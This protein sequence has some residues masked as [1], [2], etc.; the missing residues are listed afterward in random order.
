M[1]TVLLSR[2]V[3]LG[4][5]FC[6]TTAASAAP[7]LIQAQEVV[8]RNLV[9]YVQQDAILISET[10]TQT[11][12]PAPAVRPLEAPTPTPVP[13]DLSQ[14]TLLRA[15]DCTAPPTFRWTRGQR[16]AVVQTTGD[17]TAPGLSVSIDGTTVA[18]AL[19]GHPAYICTLHVQ[20]VDANPGEEV[21]A[22]WRTQKKDGATE[23]VTVFHIPETA[24]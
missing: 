14:W 1:N 2:F 15:G 4:G 23:G 11:A 22:I 20:N 8:G 16:T 19:L 10:P 12:L 9:V 6:T 7:P 13:S 21:V 5:I 3:L 24:H 17:W 18:T